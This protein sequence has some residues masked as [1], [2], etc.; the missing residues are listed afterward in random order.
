MLIWY[1]ARGA[2]VAAF[3]ALSVATAAGAITAR[4]SAAIQRRVLTQYLH[5][6]AAMTG[7]LLLGLHVYMVL[8]DSYAKVGVLGAL[9]PLAAGYRPLAVSLGVLASYLLVVVAGTGLLR[10]RFAASA[11]GARSWRAIHLAS[12]AA[13]VLAAFHFLTAG[14]DAGQG[15]AR[16]VLLAGTGIVAAGVIV[17]LT[18]PQPAPQPAA[19]PARHQLTGALR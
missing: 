19:Q 10:A 8:I 7:L 2:G 14:T 4:R 15:W 16:L 18:E 13:W 9:V 11:R 5:R 1:L 6:T 12:Y 17:R 3:A